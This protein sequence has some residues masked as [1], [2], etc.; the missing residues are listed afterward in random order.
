MTAE[1]RL[2]RRS[3]VGATAAAAIAGLAGCTAG[4]ADPEAP[5]SEAADPWPDPKTVNAR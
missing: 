2:D 5:A 1:R 3:F 4:L